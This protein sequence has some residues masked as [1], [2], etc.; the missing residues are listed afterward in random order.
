MLYTEITAD[1]KIPYA[2]YYCTPENVLEQIKKTGTA[3]V[4]DVL[5]E[6]ELKFAREQLWLALEG[7]TKTCKT[8]F[9]FADKRTWKGFYDLA[10]KHGMML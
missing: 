4:A 6:E 9:K 1:S 10:P 5:S 7:I 2:E 8:P 3:V